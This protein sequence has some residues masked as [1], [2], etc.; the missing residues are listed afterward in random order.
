MADKEVYIILSIVGVVAIVGLVFTFQGSTTSKDSNLKG[1]A[2][3]FLADY[4]SDEEIDENLVGEAAKK[5]IKANAKEKVTC[6]FTG[7]NSKQSCKSSKGK[8]SGIGSCKATVSGNKNAILQWSTPDKNCKIIEPSTTTVDGTDE[9]VE[10]DCPLPPLTNKVTCEFSG[11]SGALT[12]SS[13]LGS[14]TA[15]VS[16]NGKCTTT[17][18]G[19]LN[20]EAIWTAS[21]PSCSGSFK[22]KINGKTSYGYTFICSSVQTAKQ[23]VKCGFNNPGGYDQQCFSSMGSCHGVTSC[24]LEFIGNVGSVVT[25]SSSCGG[26]FKR[27]IA[28]TDAVL[29]FTCT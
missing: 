8:C 14:C 18:S 23:K 3:E 20:D 21:N 26:E 16:G 24:E 29:N 11:T 6:I 19:K 17:I 15:Q 28:T 4:S 7:S 10:F 2:D 13:S 12:C 5:P 27:I 1:K 9:S 22:T 25:W